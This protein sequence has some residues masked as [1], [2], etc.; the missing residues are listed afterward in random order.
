MTFASD[1]QGVALDLLSDLG[2]SITLSRVVEGDYNTATSEAGATPPTTYTGYGHPSP[3]NKNEVDGSTILMSD[4]RLLIYTTT[5]PLVGDVAT[6][7][8]V[9]H[10]VES[11]QKIRAQGTNIIYKLQLRI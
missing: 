8:G 9:A 7:D 6:I 10:R 4:I 1:L 2:E 11:V 5:T 3:Y